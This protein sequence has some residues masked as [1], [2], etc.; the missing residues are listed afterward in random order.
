MLLVTG[1]G[2]AMYHVAAAIGGVAE[3]WMMHM[4]AVYTDLV[5]APGRQA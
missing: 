3:E 1:A 2:A 5:C 4:R